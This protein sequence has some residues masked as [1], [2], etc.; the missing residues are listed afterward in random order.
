MNQSHHLMRLNLVAAHICQKALKVFQSNKMT[1]LTFI[2]KR[3]QM[4]LLNQKQ[5]KQENPWLVFS[6]LTQIVLIILNFMAQWN[7]K[8]KKNKSK[9][10][11]NTEKQ[12]IS[13][14]LKSRFQDLN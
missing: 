9:E 2:L 12:K 6:N 1:K 5:E 14:Y 7:L 11:N 10:R 3:Y 8:N 4:L 13:N